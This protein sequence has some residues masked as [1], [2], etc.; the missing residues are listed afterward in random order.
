MR[1][2]GLQ[3]CS[4]SLITLFFSCSLTCYKVHQEATC[5]NRQ[6]EKSIY[7]TLSSHNVVPTQ[8][9]NIEDGRSFM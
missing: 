9:D 1:L 2:L 4:E 7:E 6:E 5:S 8:K 3:C